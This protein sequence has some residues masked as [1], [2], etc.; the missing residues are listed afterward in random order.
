MIQLIAQRG[1][2]PRAQVG[3]II[4]Q[5][6]RVIST[7]YNGAPPG[8]PH[9]TDVGCDLR[10]AQA[11]LDIRTANEQGCRRAVHA[12]ANAIAWAARYGISVEGATLHCTHEPCL[13]CAQ[14]I[15][16]SGIVAVYWIT[17]Y[18]RNSGQDLLREAG[19]E[20]IGRL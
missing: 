5:D 7:G 19:V 9:C 3:A 17:D 11:G 14:L 13:A 16:S 12:E 20:I 2:C 10:A 6:R 4:T 8:L 18:K 1:T 15:V